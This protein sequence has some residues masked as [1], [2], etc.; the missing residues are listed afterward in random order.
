MTTVRPRPL[1]DILASRTRNCVDLASVAAAVCEAYRVRIPYRIGCLATTDP[2]TGLISW[3]WKTH[4]LNIGDEEFAAAEYGG[5]DINLFAEI[6]T[7]PEPVG[8]LSSDTDGNPGSC[9][10][11]RDFLVPRFGFTDELRVVFRSQ[12]LTWGAIALYR[13]AATRRSPRTTHTALCRFTPASPNSSR[14]PS[15]IRSPAH[16]DPASARR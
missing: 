8:A 12:G 9:R 5:W 11:F 4:P 7:R 6:G 2:S 3:A 1:A 10:R 13:G 14:M 16:R 15:P